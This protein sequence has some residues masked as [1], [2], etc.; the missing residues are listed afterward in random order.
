MKLVSIKDVETVAVS[1]L[2][3]N[4]DSADLLTP[5]VLAALVRKTASFECPCPAAVLA[6]S[7]SRL[8]EPICPDETLKGTVRRTINSVTSYGD[9]V[10]VHEATD[11]ASTFRLYLAAPSFLQVSAS[12]FLLFGVTPDGEDMT[13][14]DLR[15]KVEPVMYS[16]RLAVHDPK[17]CRDTLLLAGFESL[18]LDSW[19][20]CPPPRAPLE[21]IALY[22]DALSISGP[23][24]VPEDVSLIDPSQSVNYYTGRWTKLKKQTGRFLGRRSQAYGAQLWCYLEVNEGTVTRLLDFPRFETHWRAFDE[25]WHLLQAM[26]AVQGRPQGFRVR[27]ASQRG[28]VVIDLFS[29]VPTWAIRRWDAVG[30]RTLPDSSLISY[31]FPEKQIDS[32]CGFAAERMWLRRL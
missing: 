7:V 9:L 23:P 1:S 21:L 14:P 26:D 20:Q 28:M 13:P 18:K 3:F 16:R 4:V 24:G 32:E 17:E 10:E 29:P 5:E 15:Q 12:L 31:I 30:L 19:L 25:A 8:L 11:S 2:G 22:D 27:K 6:K